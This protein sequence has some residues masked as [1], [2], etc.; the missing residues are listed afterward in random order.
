MRISFYLQYAARNLW[1]NRRWSGFAIFCIA[2]GVATVVALRS[3]GLA[4]ADALTSDLRSSNYGDITLQKGADY[5]LFRFDS[6][7]ERAGFDDREMQRIADWTAEHGGQLSAYTVTNSIQ[8]SSLDFVGAGRPQFISTIFIDPQSFPPTGDIIATD[9][10]GVPM[11]D[12]F[13]GG[14]EVVISQNLADAQHIKVGDTVR[15]SGTS[16]EFTVRGIVPATVR[17]GFRD[18]MA[19]FF[20]FAFMNQSLAQMLPVQDMPTHVSIALPEGTDTQVIE[21]GERQLRARVGDAR[22]QTVPD[23]LRQNQ[24]IADVLGSFIVAMGLGALLIGGVGIVNTMLVMVGRRT[25]EIAALKT[26]GLRGEQVAAMFMSEAFLLGLAGSLLGGVFGVALSSFANAYGQVLIQQPLT[27]RIYPEAIFFGVVLGLIITVVFGVLPVL[28]AIKV[29]PAIIL[30]PNETFIPRAGLLQSLFA[31]GLVVLTGG[32]IAGQMLLPAFNVADSAPRVAPPNPYVV[33]I[34]VVAVTLLILSILVGLL[35][36]LVWLIGKLPSFGIID[37]R[38]ALR[39]L[40]IRRTRTATTLLALSAGMFALSS[41][42]F[43][44]AGTREILQFTLSGAMGGNVAILPILPAAIANPLI[45]SKLDSIEGVEYRTR[46]MNYNARI[47]QINGQ[48]IEAL[49]ST[50]QGEIN[51]AM[52]E[53]RRNQDF[54]QMRELAHM[55]RDYSYTLVARESDNPNLTSGDLVAGRDLTP[56]DVRE[57]VAVVQLNPLLQQLNVQVG[58]VLTFEINNRSYDF[59]VVGLLPYT[60]PEEMTMQQGMTMGDVIIPPRALDRITPSFQ[61]NVAQIAPE[62]LNKALVELS[63]LPLIYSLDISFFDSLLT[64]LINQFSSIPI[65]VGLLSLMAAGVIMANTVALSMLERRRQI[66]ILKAVG[67]RGKRVLS[68]VL[69]ENTLVSL[70]GG[71]LGIGLSSLGVVIMS[72]YGLDITLLIPTDALPVAVALVLAALFIA[73]A[74]TFLSAQTVL[75]ERVTNVLRYE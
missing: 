9:P 66:G 28:T 32:L 67:L 39:N 22:I 24:S 68:V 49:T 17:G 74:S 2:A 46:F 70:L 47:K 31:L 45:D 44:G 69:L 7:D 23:L 6:P 25:E 1:R 5:D 38:L 55:M 43:I 26:F 15:V 62:H 65:L 52:A 57:R 18:L 3:L 21:D 13:Q 56:E 12:L 75:G 19:A 72:H 64:R 48:D 34:I 61:L 16:E 41:I 73:W 33:G 29:R 53:A 8:I 60:S 27:W 20:G 71:L 36:L 51:A 14:S 40:T 30:R 59:E 50:S 37:L 58:T 10:P 11:R 35:W 54:M 63:A 4:I 42:S